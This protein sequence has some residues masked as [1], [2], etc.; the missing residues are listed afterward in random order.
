LLCTVSTVKDSRAR[1]ERFVERN[2]ASGA[3]H[4]FVMLEQ[5]DGGLVESLRAHPHVS[6]VLTDE[7]YWP[8]GRPDGLNLRQTVNADLVDTLLSVFPSVQ[9]LVH[10]DS[11]E[12]LDLDRDRLAELP[13][14]ARC[15]HLE[16]LE[17]V[18]KEHWVGEVDRF[19]R[20][21]DVADLSL[22]AALGAIEA[23]ANTS[24]F[25]GHLLGKAG[26]RPGLDLSLGVHRVRTRD[27]DTLEHVRADHLRL[28]HYE[29]FSA[30]EFIRKWDAHLSA[31][32]AAF[33]QSRTLLRSALLA[34]QRNAHL[35]PDAR[36]EYLRRLYKLRVEDPVEV[37]EELGLLAT[38]ELALHQRRPDGFAPEEGRLVDSLLSLLAVADKAGLQLGAPDAPTRLLEEVRS[39]LGPEDRVLAER[40]D[41][42]LSGSPSGEG[43]GVAGR[44]DHEAVLE[45]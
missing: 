10:L 12:C 27:G 16:V 14:D 22:L 28:L 8:G 41:A 34:L 29:S 40:I 23:P 15:F 20:R 36:R 1:V 38:P 19:K 37:L 26:A 24:Y 13:G 21:L 17:A 45:E 25:R 7:T 9:W 18:S 32:Q 42:C 33:R 44:A 30:E 11:D 2:L 3:D 31:G 5:D 4:M 35:G 6:P 39:A 43:E